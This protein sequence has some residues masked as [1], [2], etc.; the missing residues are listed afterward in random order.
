MSDGMPDRPTLA[1]DWSDDDGQVFD[2]LVEPQAN[3][4]PVPAQTMTDPVQGR[5][6]RAGRLMTGNATVDPT[7]PPMLALPADPARR[8]LVIQNNS[9]TATD[10]VRVA[11]DSGKCQAP[12]GAGLV[13]PANPL[14]LRDYTGP[15]WLSGA[16]AAGVLAVSWWAVTE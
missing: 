10:A 6:K 11:D 5:P 7:W 13:Y 15:V 8:S 12:A 9:E 2:S 16:D 3:P 14:T 1:G 4:L